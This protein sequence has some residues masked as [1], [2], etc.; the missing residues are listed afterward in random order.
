MPSF[1]L[2]NFLESYPPILYDYSVMFLTMLF[3]CLLVWTSLMPY[4]SGV[5][6]IENGKYDVSL[7]F[8]ATLNHL[9]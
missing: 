4:I 7:P 5:H 8:P 6:E 9:S 1:H 3:E 2:P